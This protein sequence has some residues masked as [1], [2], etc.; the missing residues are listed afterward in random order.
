MRH[1]INDDDKRVDLSV[2]INQNL[3]KLL[4][5]ESDRIG[6]NKSKII[7]KLLRNH[8]KEKGIDT[9]NIL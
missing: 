6:I 8:L 1:K 5:E 9:D 3:F 2:T 4:N 7:E